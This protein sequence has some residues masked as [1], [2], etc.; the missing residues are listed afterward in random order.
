[1]KKYKIIIILGILISLFI[2]I[3]YLIMLKNYDTGEWRI[4]KNDEFSIQYPS[5]WNLRGPV[6][7]GA[8]V[9]RIELINDQNKIS[10]SWGSGGFGGG[11]DLLYQ[12]KIWIG[13]KK[14]DGC[15]SSRN[16]KENWWA[17]YLEN[18]D[19]TFAPDIEVDKSMTD[20]ANKILSTFIFTN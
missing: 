10:I 17:V 16:G 18:K 3:F 1:M 9:S 2:G 20:T 5:A 13:N 11:C 6:K 19:K 14:V 15:H 7:D 8:E 4:Y 12:D